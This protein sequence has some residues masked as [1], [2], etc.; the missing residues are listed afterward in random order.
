MIIGPY[1]L[2]TRHPVTEAEANRLIS[3]IPATLEKATKTLGGRGSLQFL[4][5]IAGRHVAIKPYLRG[6]LMGKIN[7]RFYVGRGK[8]RAAIEYDFLL[9]LTETA[10]NTPA[11]FGIIETGRFI[12]S[13]WIL[14]ETVPHDHTLATAPLS[15]KEMATLFDSLGP[16]MK[17]LLDLGVHHVDLHPGNIIITREGH[18]VLIDFDKARKGITDRAALAACYIKRWTRAVEKHHLDQRLSAAFEQMMQTL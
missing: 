16:Q 18:P 7:R 13:C 15:D 11:P 1:T 4:D 10:V 14:M 5:E 9:A 17:A 12:R 2:T 6:G 3:A 8:T